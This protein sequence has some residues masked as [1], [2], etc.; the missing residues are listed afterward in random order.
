MVTEH[1]QPPCPRFLARSSQRFADPRI[2]TDILHP[3]YPPFHS[4]GIGWSD[5]GLYNMQREERY[6]NK[7]DCGHHGCDNSIEPLDWDEIYTPGVSE[8]EIRHRYDRPVR[9]EDDT[10]NMQ[11]ISEEQVNDWFDDELDHGA[12]DDGEIPDYINHI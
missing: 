8:E 9:P 12:V 2:P 5:Q 4:N 6:I 11:D 10:L 3:N 7:Q 1:H